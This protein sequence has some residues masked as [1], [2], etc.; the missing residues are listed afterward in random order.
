M[1]KLF[2]VLITLAAGSLSVYAGDGDYAVSR[3]PAQLLKNAHIVK[4]M[5]EIRLE[6]SSL[7]KVKVYEKFAITVLDENGDPYA[8]LYR[9][10]DKLRSIQSIEGRLYDANGKKLKSLKKG[11]IEDR[12]GVSEASLMEDDRLKIHSF[13]YRVYP[14]TVE[15]EVE[16]SLNNTYNFPVWFPQPIE[17]YAVQQSSFSIACPAD[18]TFRYKVFNYPGEP[19]ILQVKDD[20]TYKWEIKDLASIVEEYA[21]PDFRTLTT[22]IFFSPDK[23]RIDDYTGD[24]SSWQNFGKFIYELNAGRD[25]LPDAIKQKVHQLTDGLSDSKDKVNTLYEYM[26]KN[27]RYISIQLGIG[28]MQPFDASYVANKSYGDCKA[29]SNYMCALL[30]EA[31]IKANYTLIKSGRNEKYFMPDFP[32]D[33]FDHII[34]CVPLQKDTI[35]LECTSQTLPAG[36]LSDFTADR[37]AL[38]VGEEG[39]KLVHTPKY[40]M[41]ENLQVRGIKARLEDDGTLSGTIFTRYSGL[42]QDGIHDL[43]NHLSKDKVKEVL[44]EELD[45]ATYDVNRFDYKENRSQ[46]PVIEETLE[47]SVS[48]Y[49]TITGKRLFIIPNVMNRSH[50]KLKTDE[51]RKYNIEL[52]YEYKDIDSVEI[53]I[54]KGYEPEAIPQPA[55]IES[56]FGKYSSRIKLENNKIYF[57]RNCEQYSG[58]FSARDYAAMVNYYDAIYKADR[59]KIVFVKKENN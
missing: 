36:Y 42:Q 25:K 38:A 58:T 2:S 13:Y 1:K 12:S 11:D 28:G 37:F 6:I 40:N 19:V 15:Y 56:K 41:S 46:K 27:T 49:G 4:R 35:W 30:K 52:N 55:T 32:S 18:F 48:N 10:Y 54:P 34:L 22:C 31:N 23:F 44:R 24:L 50:R 9:C 45:F 17:N 33:Q 7:N 16:T 51:E 53:E 5:E 39:G 43:I 57:Y 14:Y 47:V 59:N 21:S 20:K 26:Q 8:V 29:L 3:I